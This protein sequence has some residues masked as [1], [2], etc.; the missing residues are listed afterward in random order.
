MT[1]IIDDLTDKV[2]HAV[3]PDEMKQKKENK[4]YYKQISNN[5]DYLNNALL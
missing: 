5:K 4:K 2:V 1:F 3:L